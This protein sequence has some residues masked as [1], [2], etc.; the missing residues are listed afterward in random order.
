MANPDDTPCK[1]CVRKRLSAHIA[2][3]RPDGEG[4]CLSDNL[5]WALVHGSIKDIR[6]G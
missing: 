6:R 3:G 4:V 2:E 1:Y 5:V